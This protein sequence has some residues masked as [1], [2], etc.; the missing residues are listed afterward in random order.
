MI[1]RLLIFLVVALVLLAVSYSL[2]TYFLEQSDIRLDFSLFKVYL[3]HFFAALTIYTGVEVI[4][5]K[6]P[7]QAGYAF[8]VGLTIKIGLFILIFQDTF[9]ALKGMPMVGRLA[10]LL[11]MFLFLILESVFLGKLLNDS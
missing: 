5:S 9:S 10:L 7:S 6:L 8:L 3:F 1:K 2:H 11:P 4:F